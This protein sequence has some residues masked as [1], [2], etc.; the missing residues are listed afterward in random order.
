MFFRKKHKLKNLTDEDLIRLYRKEEDT[1]YVGELFERY[2][3]LAFLVSMKYLKDKEEAKDVTMQV[4]ERLIKDLKKYEVRSF[5]YWLHTVVKN[6]CL[7]NLDKQ[8]RKREKNEDYR[9]SEMAIMELE[10]GPS[11]LGE[12]TPEELRLGRLEEAIKNLKNDQKT[13]IELFF[14]QQKSYKEITEMTGF[15]LLQVKS[16]IQN[17]KRNLKIQLSKMELGE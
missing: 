17:G 2:T 4:F 10:P 15:S 13:C 8:Q 5:K 1:V 7:A 14:L 9:E 11:L 3:D 12:T 16:H 6:Q